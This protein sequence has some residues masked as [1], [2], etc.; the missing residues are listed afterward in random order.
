[1]E[2]LLRRAG[3]PGWHC[4]GGEGGVTSRFMPRFTLSAGGAA[5]LALFCAAA[6]DTKDEAKCEEALKVGRQALEVADFGLAQK[7]REYAW[8]HCADTN[9]LDGLDKEIVAKQSA[10]EAKKQE[11]AQRKEQNEALLKLFTGWIGAQRTAPERASA[12][13]KCDEPATKAATP[14]PPKPEDQERFCTATRVAGEYTLAV[15]YWEADK[16]A[17]RFTTRPKAP[18]TCDD[19]GPNRPIKSWDVP[20]VDGRSVKRSRCELTGGPLHGLQVLVSA[21]NNA[22]VHVFSPQYL[23]KD[24]A[25]A[26]YVAGP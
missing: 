18:V 7:W 1:M 10:I 16:N 5:L 4:Q 17:L 14:S 24:P 11:E 25:M 8:K 23:E 26:R 19:I 9:A 6:C 22:D 13:P 20:A 2:T 15:R 21:A 3:F 12:A